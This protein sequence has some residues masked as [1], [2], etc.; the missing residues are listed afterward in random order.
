MANQPVV[1]STQCYPQRPASGVNPLPPFPIP[2]TQLWS[3]YPPQNPTAAWSSYEPPP[4]GCV[5]GLDGST[6]SWVPVPTRWEVMCLVSAGVSNAVPEAPTD[7]ND[8]V[9]N[10]ETK[11]W[12]NVQDLVLDGG[13][14]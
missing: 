11:T 1:P 3:G 13:T 4:T 9:R 6:Q 2:P 5:Y 7:G 8:Y 10:G 12:I 14:Y